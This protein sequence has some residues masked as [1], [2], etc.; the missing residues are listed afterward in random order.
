[1]SQGGRK[2][3]VCGRGKCP[4]PTTSLTLGRQTGHPGDTGAVVRHSAAHYIRSRD[5]FENLRNTD[6]RADLQA[7]VAA[8]CPRIMNT[9]SM[10][11]LCIT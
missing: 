3:V 4:S 1:M 9:G 2:G 5:L 7:A 10:R 11:L 8:D 6:A